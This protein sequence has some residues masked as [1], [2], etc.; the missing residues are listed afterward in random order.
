MAFC[1]NCGTSN[2]EQAEN[3]V[4][5]GFELA[6]KQKAKFKGTIMMSG[7]KVPG[8][9]P[10][11]APGSVGDESGPAPSGPTAPP[12]APTPSTPTPSSPSSQPPERNLAFQ[13]TMVG[14]AGLVPPPSPQAQPRPAARPA[15]PQDLAHAP[16]MQ[17]HGPSVAQGA[18]AASPMGGARAAER[19][20]PSFSSGG[21]STTAAGAF[22]AATSSATI[23]STFP[24]ASSRKP[25]PG[26][27]LAIGCGAALLLA[28]VISGL[29]W[30]MI[31]SKIKG[32]FS[33]GEDSGAEAAA[34]QQSIAQSLAQ[35]AT[36][37]K[38][39][40][41]QA[42]VFFHANVRTAFTDE[43]KALTDERIEKL[44]NPAS[45]KAQML[46]GTEDEEIATK[47]GLDPQQCARV[48]AGAG[49]VV[50]CSVPEPGGKPSVL[51]IVHLSGMKSL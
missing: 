50:S 10:G 44:S 21:T 45:S 48:V 11:A 51:R 26:K 1:P 7:V 19:S 24:G 47:L 37:C 23:D 17:G 43:A 27:L 30:S 36:L 12:T 4:S 38:S 49:K 9:A 31:G 35:V 33:G 13:K 8:G 46:N 32:A 39:D 18:T 14:H 3:C 42:G 2:T 15:G 20:A 40:C 6:P 34:W 16:T 29:V 28:C 22:T 41:E 5:C 25:N